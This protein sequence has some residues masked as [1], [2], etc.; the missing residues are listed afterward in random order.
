MMVF[1]CPSVHYLCRLTFRTDRDQ[2]RKME[3]IVAPGMLCVCVCVCVRVCVCV[4][5]CVC[6]C[7]SVCAV[8][9]TTDNEVTQ[10][11]D[12]SSQI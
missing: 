5:V 6:M 9:H 11:D 7:V 1:E 2:V 8:H 4:C 3:F 12:P 10:L